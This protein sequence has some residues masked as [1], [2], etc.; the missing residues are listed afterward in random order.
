MSNDTQIDRKAAAPLAK[1]VTMQDGSTASFGNRARLISE[2]TIREDGFTIFF[3]LISG[4]IIDYVFHCDVGIPK[5][6]LEMAAFGA[7]NK[8]KAATAGLKKVDD[9]EKTIRLKV[10]EFTKGIF[11]TRGAPAN[12]LTLTMTQEAYCDMKQ[13]DKTSSEVVAT[14]KGI[15]ADFSS[16]EKSTLVTSAAM[17][18]AMGAIR[19]AQAQAELAA[20]I[21]AE[22]DA[23]T[24]ADAVVEMA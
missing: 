14:V 11:V 9:I 24:E 20:D 17:K 3:K 5:L 15:F 2:Q 13:L 16:G 1:V 6:M 22:A 21:A 18:V 7:A 12:S 10:E 4:V 8:A 19:L 23:L